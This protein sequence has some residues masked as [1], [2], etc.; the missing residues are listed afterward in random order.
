MKDKSRPT[1]Q[2][3]QQATPAEL[4]NAVMETVRHLYCKD[5]DD[6]TWM[7]NHYH[8]IRKWCVLWAA[9]FVVKKGFV[10][11]AN[12]FKEIL[13]KVLQEAKF[14]ATAKITY[15]PAFLAKCVQSH[16]EHH[17]ET[18]YAEAKAIGAQ[19]DAAIMGLGKLAETPDR[20]VENLAAVDRVLAAPKRKARAVVAEKQITLL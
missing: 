10:L 7:K 6:K 12:R 3:L 2:K 5:V 16:F 17:W 8:F 13:V 9:T 19:A 14:K 15:P 20:T 18:Y 4:V 11:P 1:R